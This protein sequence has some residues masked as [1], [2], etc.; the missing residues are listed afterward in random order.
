MCPCK[1]TG[2]RFSIPEVAGLRI[3]TFPALSKT[4]SNPKFLP[5]SRIYC[6]IFSK[7]PEGRGILQIALK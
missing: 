2:F 4:V 6:V 1:T 5:K 7:C 3:K